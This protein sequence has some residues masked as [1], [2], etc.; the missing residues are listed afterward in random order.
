MLNV[1]NKDKY[2]VV[3]VGYF[4]GGEE[5]RRSEGVGEDYFFFI[6][7]GV[8]IFY[9]NV[10]SFYFENVSKILKNVFMYFL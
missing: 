3:N 8:Y 9:G 1:K 7:F 5:G 2:Q 10:I 4:K 6:Q